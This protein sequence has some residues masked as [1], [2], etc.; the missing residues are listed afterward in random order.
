MK[1]KMERL[2]TKKAQQDT[3]TPTVLDFTVT[4]FVETLI[5]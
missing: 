2:R 4:Q 3:P 1:E 5:G